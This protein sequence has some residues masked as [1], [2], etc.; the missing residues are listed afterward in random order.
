MARTGDP[1]HI[2]GISGAKFSAFKDPVLASDGGVA[3]PATISGGGVK[4][5]ARQTLW[6]KPPGD[7]LRLLAQAGAEPPAVPGA[8]WETLASLAIASGHG[9]IFTATLVAGQGGVT[10]S[11]ATGLWAMASD[12]AL[13][14]L[15]RTGDKIMLDDATERKVRSFSVLKAVPGSVGVTRSFNDRGVVI[16]KATFTDG[17]QGVI[18]TAIP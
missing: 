14:L 17:T 1:A 7:T 15:F 9:P 12:G 4:G 10:A 6:W 18:Q 3:F 2:P 5:A 16:W 11:N 13:Q 8:R